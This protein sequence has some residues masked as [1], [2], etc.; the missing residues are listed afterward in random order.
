[1]GYISNNLMP[2]EEIIYFGYVHWF[3]FVPGLT[4]FLVG[5]SVLVSISLIGT[6]TVQEIDYLNGFGFVVGLL[7]ILVALISLVGALI[8]KTSTELAVTTKRVI[9]KVGFIRR[10]TV[11]LNHNKVESFAV[12]QSLFGRL[13]NFGTIAIIGTGGGTNTIRDIDSPLEFRRQAVK[14]ID[15]V[16]H[17]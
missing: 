12:K 2:E 10:E 1:M 15:A 14:I 6:D 7:L 11:E 4:Q 5:I 9:T 8:R 13:F 16:S 3:I 17:D